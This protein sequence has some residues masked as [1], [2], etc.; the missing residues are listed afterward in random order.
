LLCE[1]YDTV[2]GKDRSLML[3]DSLREARQRVVS[4]ARSQGSNHPAYRE[5]SRSNRV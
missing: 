3:C 4:Q 2:I 1:W 5:R